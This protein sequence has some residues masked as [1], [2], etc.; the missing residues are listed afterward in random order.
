MSFDLFQHQVQQSSESFSS[1]GVPVRI[2]SFIPIGGSR[3][4]A[5]IA[6]HGSGGFHEG[7]ANDPARLLASNGFAVF[8]LHYFERTGTSWADRTTIERNFPVWMS[9]VKDAITHIGM[10][11]SVDRRRIG[12]L[13]FSLGGYLAVSVAATDARVKAVVEFFG[14]LPNELATN[15]HAMPPILILHG[16]ADRVVPVTEAH[17]LEDV[18]KRTGSTYAIKIYSGVG[19]G[20]SGLTMFDSAQRTL[21]FLRT[22][23]ASVPS[24]EQEQEAEAAG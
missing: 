2:D 14:G 15:V 11:P 21:A 22:H 18:L 9:V 5:V 20:F 19:H 7:F 1:S 16:D 12:L 24:T 17:K 8:I 4:P 13:G 3:F 10:S 6:L 23:L